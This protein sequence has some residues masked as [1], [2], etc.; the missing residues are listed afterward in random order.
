M[1][2][3]VAN[4]SAVPAPAAPEVKINGDTVSDNANVNDGKLTFE[5]PEGIAVYYR[6]DPNNTPSGDDPVNAPAK[7]APATMDNDGKV[8]TLYT[9]EVKLESGSHTVSYFAYDEATGLK[10]EVKTINVS[11]TT[12]I[13]GVAAEDGAVEWFNLQGVRVAEP[14]Q[15]I[16]VRVANGK[17]AKVVVE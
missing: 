5:V 17:A 9:G 7:A 2:L 6:I 12:G 1:S 13:E 10:S 3:Y 11:N 4:Y 15:G 14:Q 8:Y 16:Y